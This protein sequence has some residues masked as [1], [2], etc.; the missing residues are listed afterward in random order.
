MYPSL[1]PGLGVDLRLNRD[2]GFDCIEL[3][4]I[5]KHVELQRYQ[6]IAM[7]RSINNEIPNHY[8]VTDIRESYC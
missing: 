6:K 4:T 3:I 7:D 1:R 5:E 2:F 8:E